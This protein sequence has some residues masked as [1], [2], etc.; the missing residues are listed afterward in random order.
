MVVLVLRSI[1]SL[2][3]THLDRSVLEPSCIVRLL[4]FFQQ[5]VSAKFGQ[6]ELALA[7]KDMLPF[8]LENW[9]GALA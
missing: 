7:P 1:C 8:D 9:A 2:L 4:L 3:A 5:C 6:A